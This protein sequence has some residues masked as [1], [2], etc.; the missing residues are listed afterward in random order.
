MPRDDYIDLG[1]L[2][3][4]GKIIR[5]RFYPNQDK[6]FAQLTEEVMGNLDATQ[7][8]I[9]RQYEKQTIREWEMA[10]IMEIGLRHDKSST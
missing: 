3:P 1:V 6:T 4:D 8:E 2:A 5:K 9:I 7:R 10:T